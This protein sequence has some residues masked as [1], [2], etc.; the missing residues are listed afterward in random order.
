MARALNKQALFEIE[1]QCT[2]S[3]SVIQHTNLYI[4][5]FNSEWEVRSKMQTMVPNSNL[6]LILVTIKFP[7]NWKRIG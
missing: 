7:Y 5:S 2:Y 1:G 4:N 3:D 6:Y